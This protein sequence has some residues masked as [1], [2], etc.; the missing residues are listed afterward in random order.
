MGISLKC[1][2]DLISTFLKV[3]KAG[4]ERWKSMSPAVSLQASFKL[5]GTNLDLLLE[6][7]YQPFVCSF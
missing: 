3:G 7:N 5:N 6:Q 4:G 1:E 2:I